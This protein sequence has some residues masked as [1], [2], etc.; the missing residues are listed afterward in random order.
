MKEVG[1][2]LKYRFGEIS[3]FRPDSETGAKFLL[4]WP[5][6]LL[7]YILLCCDAWE[8][9]ALNNGRELL[10]KILTPMLCHVQIQ[11]AALSKGFV[12]PVAYKRFLTRVGTQVSFQSVFDRKAFFALTA[13]KG[14]LTRVG[15]QV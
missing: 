5:L 15:T 11:V 7:Q 6:F 9:R 1:S 8:L 4:F 12:A 3:S 10:R 13:F 14:L 2:A